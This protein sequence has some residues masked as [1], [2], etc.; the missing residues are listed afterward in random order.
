[1]N[2][3][4][5]ETI[6]NRMKVL[7]ITQ[8]MMAEELDVSS[9][10]IS[11]W[12]RGKATPSLERLNEMADVVGMTLILADRHELMIQGLPDSKNLEERGKIIESLE[13]LLVYLKKN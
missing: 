2:E 7:G 11:K 8:E 12:L 5:R 3:L 1:M 9:A 6:K 10:V 4:L 13:A